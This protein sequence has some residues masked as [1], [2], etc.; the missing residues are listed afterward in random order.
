MIIIGQVPHCQSVTPYHKPD[1]RTIMSKYENYTWHHTDT[2]TVNLAHA[3]RNLP[4]NSSD[5]Y[6]IGRTLTGNNPEKASNVQKTK[7]KSNKQVPLLT[8]TCRAELCRHKQSTLQAG[9][10]NVLPQT[11]LIIDWSHRPD[12]HI[13]L[14]LGWTWASAFLVISTWTSSVCLSV[15]QSIM[16]RQLTVNHFRLLFCAFCVVR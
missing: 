10:N 7:P 2:V 15:C 11:S 9:A 1:L 3:M 4:T 12:V 8:Y 6:S 16:D 13:L 14:L 5:L